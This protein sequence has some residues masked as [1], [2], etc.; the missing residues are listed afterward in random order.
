[1]N[2]L[3]RG[4]SI[5]K[6]IFKYFFLETMFAFLVSFLFF[7]F[8]FFV[9]QLLLMAQQILEKRVPFE[10]VALLVLFSLPSIV[11]MSAPFA[12]LLGTLM[13]IGRMS[14]DNEILVMLSSGLSYRNIFAPTLLV[15]IIVSL[16]SFVA[17]DILLPA[18]TIQFTKLYRQI[19]V[20][21]PAL[22]LESNSVKRFNDTFVITGNVSGNSIDDL[23]ILDKTSEGERRVIMAKNSE[24]IDAGKEGLRLDLENAF[25]QS[26]KEIAR[27]NYDY[28]KSDFLRY[29]LRPEDFVT[30]INPVSPREMSSRDVLREIHEKEL[31]LRVSLLDRN[32]RTL[33]R[34]LEIESIM[35]GGNV[36][37]E[38]RNINNMAANFL[39]EYEISEN[40][41]KDRNLLIYRLEFYKKFSI[42]FG[43]L[44]FIFL[45]VPLGLYAKKSG[46]TIGFIL[47]LIIA[48]FYWALLLGGQNMGMRLGYSPFWSMWLP[49]I[50]S[51]GIGGIMCLFRVRR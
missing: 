1:M 38:W 11:A 4:G 23:L 20:A 6:T 41:Q 35:R 8:I 2:N 27:R 13:T 29:R 18:G 43:S 30:N 46:Q 21:T 25:V 15:G 44:T 32:S 48:V 50:L 5:S 37:P 26:S 22:E 28:A 16:F 34:A 24:F 12:T 40:L 39:R 7:F 9:N 49:N 3:V 17:N 31:A 47:G 45:A 51:F 10:Q 14:S 19:L 33:E 42:P 36:S